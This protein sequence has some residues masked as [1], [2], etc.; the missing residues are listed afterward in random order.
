MRLALIL[1]AVLLLTSA[2]AQA[3]PAPPEPKSC[4]VQL[5]EAQISLE[6]LERT[7]KQ[8]RQQ[9][10]ADLARWIARAT[11]AEKRLAQ[12]SPPPATPPSE[13]AR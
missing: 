9:A 1:G 3:Q 10:A 4:E 8:D 11:Q 2:L 12:Q 5:S 6:L 7:A 13:G